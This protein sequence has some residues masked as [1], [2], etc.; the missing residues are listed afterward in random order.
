MARKPPKNI[1]LS[2]KNVMILPTVFAN[3]APNAPS[4]SMFSKT[5]T[6]LYGLG[7]K[8]L[9]IPGISSIFFMIS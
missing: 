1:V 9:P 7:I 4:I 6:I 2:M 5:S 3:P 8:N